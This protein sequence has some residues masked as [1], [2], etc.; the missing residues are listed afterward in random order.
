MFTKGVD[1]APENHTRT[2]TADTEQW[3]GIFVIPGD[4]TRKE[5]TLAAVFL[6]NLFFEWSG[7]ISR[8]R[9]GNVSPFGSGCEGSST[10]FSIES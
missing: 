1:L 8:N 9:Q 7:G 5:R 10:S 6:I 2:A 4:S 3:T